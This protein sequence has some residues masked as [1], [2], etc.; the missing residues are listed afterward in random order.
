MRGGYYRI[1]EIRKREGLPP[2]PNGDQL[3]ISRD[4]LPVSWIVKNPDLL[5]SSG[6]GKTNGAGEDS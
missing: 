5:V 1:N 6:R 2:D 4:L 3:L